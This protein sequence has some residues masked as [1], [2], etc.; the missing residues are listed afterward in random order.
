MLYKLQIVYKMALR[1]LIT[2]LGVCTL[3]DASRVAAHS[4]A[5]TNSQS[6]LKASVVPE[7]SRQALSDWLHKS[8]YK[9]V[10]M[11]VPDLEA[12]TYE[13]GTYADFVRD[14]TACMGVCF[15]AFD[16]TW[17]A[18]RGHGFVPASEASMFTWAPDEVPG[19][20][21]AMGY[22]KLKM[23]MPFKAQEL[24]KAMADWNGKFIEINDANELQP[25]WVV[26][27]LKGGRM[28]NRKENLKPDGMALWKQLTQE[29]KDGGISLEDEEGTQPTVD[30]N[31][32]EPPEPSKSPVKPKPEVTPWKPPKTPVPD[33]PESGFSALSHEEIKAMVQEIVEKAA[34]RRMPEIEEA[35]IAAAQQAMEDAVKDRARLVA[36]EATTDIAS[37][38]FKAGL[39]SLGD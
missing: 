38:L 1:M 36:R 27:K 10:I 5:H 4:R 34:E 33:A 2:L 39:D 23:Q 6:T 12:T 9:Y 11:T 8:A 35:A 13:K 14:F 21:S 16:F 15:G 30:D 19:S 7:R 17:Q 26:P 22:M 20:L 3:V 32:K 31:S 24:K 18:P 37:S 29:L 25:E 28:G